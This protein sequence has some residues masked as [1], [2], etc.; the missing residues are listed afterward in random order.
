MFRLFTLTLS[1]VV[2]TKLCTA[3]DSL[4]PFQLSRRGVAEVARRTGLQWDDINN[5]Y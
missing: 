4:G 2:N 5:F 1:N 3:S